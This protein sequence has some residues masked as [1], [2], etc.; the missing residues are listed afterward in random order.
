MARRL[1]RAL[2]AALALGVWVAGFE[3][4]PTLHVSLHDLWGDHTHGAHGG[5]D[6]AA[7]GHVHRTSAPGGE[8]GL[9]Q[10]ERWR[11][12]W[13]TRHAARA[14]RLPKDAARAAVRWTA[15]MD[16]HGR[17]SLAHRDL[18]AE[19]ARDALPPVGP[20]RLAGALGRPLPPRVVI[21]SPRGRPR[22]RGPPTVA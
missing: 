13:A 2:S 19:P 4:G 21:G 18:A 9:D 10:L 7:D 12:R 20:P 22:A 6:H 15:P 14:Q 11:A 5:A 8:H 3:L 16:D 1:P 17:G